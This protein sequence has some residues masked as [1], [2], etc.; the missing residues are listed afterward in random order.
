MSLI[1]KLIVVHSVLIT[2][3]VLL[4]HYEGVLIVR[5]ITCHCTV[6][7]AVMRAPVIRAKGLIVTI[8]AFCYEHVLHNEAHSSTSVYCLNLSARIKFWRPLRRK[9]SQPR[10]LNFAPRYF[11]SVLKFKVLNTIG[12][13]PVHP[14]SNSYQRCQIITEL[15][16]H[17]SCTDNHLWTVHHEPHRG[18]GTN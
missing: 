1:M 11:R 5:L 13:N 9:V 16:I 10:T 18:C 6:L 14:F 7:L 12:A 4:G 2:P 8:I 15:F 3:K 17:T